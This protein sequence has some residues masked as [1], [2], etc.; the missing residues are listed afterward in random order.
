MLFSSELCSDIIVTPGERRLPTAVE[1]S[2]QFRGAVYFLSP[3][4][5]RVAATIT[6]RPERPNVARRTLGRVCER[7]DVTAAACTPC[8]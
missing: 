1:R 7:T 6:A 8:S 2:R 5:R 4:F 3:D